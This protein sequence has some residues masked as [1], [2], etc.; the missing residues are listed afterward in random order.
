LRP[1]TSLVVFPHNAASLLSSRD[2][3]LRTENEIT[4]VIFTKGLGNSFCI[5]RADIWIS[6]NVSGRTSGEIGGKGE[7]GASNP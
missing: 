1:K 7:G 4:R 6:V 5:A 2:A 3:Q